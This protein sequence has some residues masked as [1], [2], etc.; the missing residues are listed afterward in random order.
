MILNTL[1][2]LCTTYSF[3]SLIFENRTIVPFLLPPS[4]FTGQSRYSRR[5]VFHWCSIFRA[6][7]L[8]PNHW[9]HVVPRRVQDLEGLLTYSQCKH[10][11]GGP[12]S[13]QLPQAGSNHKLLYGHS[14]AFQE[15]ELRLMSSPW[16]IK[17]STNFR[18][19]YFC[20]W[21]MECVG[22]QTEGKRI[23]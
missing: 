9:G 14:S 23:S 21:R 20:G 22:G 1:T 6:Q 2:L 12:A 11:L 10:F 7:V 8:A 17:T 15:L 4:P 13:F 3:K 19:I 5:H 16:L 18:Y